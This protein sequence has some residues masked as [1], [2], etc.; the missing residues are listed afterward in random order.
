MRRVSR[1]TRAALL[2]LFCVIIAAMPSPAQDRKK[3][4]IVYSTSNQDVSYQPYGAFAQ[5]VGWYRDEG[6]DVT[7]Q[8]AANNGLIIQ[9][10]LTGQ[11]QF[12]M[13]GP[14]PILLAAAEKPL[15]LKY[16]YPIARKMI[17]AG[18]VK[19]DSPIS[20]FADMKGKTVGM[21]SLS[22]QLIPF[23]NSRLAEHGLSAK[24]VKLVDVGYG[25]AS[26]EALKN[27]T[28]DMFV[29]WPGLFAA[30]ENAGYKFKVLP[31]A[32]WQKDYYGIGLATTSD[33]LAKNPDVVEKIGRGL[34]KST[35]LL[36]FNPDAMIEPF[37]KSYPTQAPLPIDD[38]K[39][40]FEKERNILRATAEQMRVNELPATF[41]WGSQD[42]ATWERHLKR[43]KETK[44]IPESA[45][46]D[47]DAY[48]TD[49]FAARYNAFDRDSVA[50]MK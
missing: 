12:G 43:L 13:L 10:L 37:W 22:S 46:I 19:P 7:I 4:T 15:P 6:L 21:P 26:M 36:K 40:A 17:F 9:L 5:Q 23:V 33:Y 50:K 18:V 11:A 25:V 48:F 30:F 44:L 24:D 31:D 1:L 32:P 41:S 2:G 39:K 45:N 8:T 35:V 42:R 28:I 29:A 3:V 20:S 47:V 27:G 38:R 49:A 16:I 14:D 34:A